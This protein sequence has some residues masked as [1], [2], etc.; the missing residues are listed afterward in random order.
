MLGDKDQNILHMAVKHQQENEI[1]YIL[2]DCQIIDTLVNQRDGDGN[3]SLHLLSKSN[4]YVPQLIKHPMADK[5]VSNY[6]KMTPLD[7]VTYN[8]NDTT[9]IIKVRKYF[10]QLNVSITNAKQA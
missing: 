2:Q 3:T 9:T 7:L 6:D 4:F 1:Q 5:G 8:V 10:F